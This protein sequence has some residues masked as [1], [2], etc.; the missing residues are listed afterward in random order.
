[1]L[2]PLAACSYSGGDD[3]AQF[4][5]NVCSSQA[6]CGENAECQD[7]MCVAQRVDNAALT[8]VLQVTPVRTLDGSDPVPIVLERFRVEG[9]LESTFVLPSSVSVSGQILNSASSEQPL[10][11]E[12]N[13][14][15]MDMPSGFAARM[16]SASTSAEATPSGG[17]QVQ[18]LRGIQYRVLIRP[19]D[20]ALP[21]YTQTFVA[22]DDSELSFDFAALPEHERSFAIDNVPEG[23]SLLVRALDAATLEPISSTATVTD[24]QATLRFA[25]EPPPLRI[26]IR[27]DQAYPQTSMLEGASCNSQTPDFPTFT[28][29]DSDLETDRDG[30]ARIVL[31]DIPERIRFEGRVGRCDMAMQARMLIDTLPI[32]LHGQSLIL[33]EA[34]PL[35]ATYEATTT[36]TLDPSTGELAFCVEVMP[37]AYDVLATPPSSMPCSLYAE[38]RLIAAP[39]GEHASGALLELPPAASLRATLQTTDGAPLAG[40]SVEAVALGR[41]TGVDLPEDDATITRYNRSRQTASMDDGMFT[42]PVDLGSYDVV[43]KPPTGSGFSW[44]VHYDVNIGARGREFRTVIDMVSPVAVSG[45][46]RYSDSDATTGLENAEV[47]AFAIIDD[48]SGDPGTERALPLGKA[49]A[50]ADGRFTLLLP[51]ASSSAGERAPPA[52]PNG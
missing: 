44:Q 7:G 40:A 4:E 29:A 32:T 47:A 11:A 22:D 30:V 23:R 49:T 24:G 42:V 18:L 8:V 37:G 12:I 48:E 34:S 19:G 36:A 43:V 41:H 10:D 51:P 5:M 9:P 27:T 3:G 33:P 15:P 39:E 6:D 13:F 35:T 20:L 38:H 28:V 31:P 46:L 2:A 17:Y 25:A 52:A 26:E 1:M 45:R 14:V 50:D 21:P 16:I